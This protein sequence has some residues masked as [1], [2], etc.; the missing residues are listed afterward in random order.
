MNLPLQLLLA[1]LQTED[2]TNYRYTTGKN[3][4][5][6]AVSEKTHQPQ[7][8]TIQYRVQN[9]LCLTNCILKYSI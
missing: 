4:S 6:S 7:V 9:K 2:I 3:F 5:P 8:V 1:L